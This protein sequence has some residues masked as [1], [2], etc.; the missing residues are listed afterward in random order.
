MKDIISMDTPAFTILAVLAAVGV[1]AILYAFSSFIIKR[2]KDKYPILNTSPVVL[3]II[4]AFGL[5]IVYKIISGV[6][7]IIR[8][9]L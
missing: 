9:L 7:L 1:L 6:V 3:A 8:E 2:Y 5:L 4:L